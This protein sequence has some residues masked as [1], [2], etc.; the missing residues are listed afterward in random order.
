[1]A[2][3][4]MPPHQGH[5]AGMQSSL[6]AD[7]DLPDA[8]SLVAS[9]TRRA[10][11]GHFDE[12]CAS[13]SGT[14]ASAGHAPAP[15]WRQFFQTLG[16]DGWAD[17]AARAQ[18]VQAQ[19][20]ED[21]ATY[22]V[23]AE[24]V[25]TPRAWPLELL[26][27]IVPAAEWALIEAGVTQRA[28]L[29]AATLT[30]LYGP[31]TLMRDALLPA[32]LVFAH[33]HYL[34]PACGL[35]S[36]DRCGLHIAA[37]DLARTPEGGFQ[38]LAQR[39]QAPSG[40]GYLLESRLIIGAQFQDQFADLRVQR[41]AST[42]R[43]LLDGLVRVSPAGER[44]RVVL[45][46]PGPLNETYFEQ[47]F[48]ARYLGVTLVEGSDLTVR[49]KKLY[50]KTLHGLEQV[51]V[52]LRRVDDEFL[53][54]L[55]LRP[56]SQL[57][58]PGLLQALRAG[59]VVMANSPGAGVLESPGLAAFWPGVAERL[60]G[61]D[62]LLPASTSWWC[63]EPTV[64]QNQRDALANFV[65]APTFPDS[66]FGPRVAALMSEAERLALRDRID[67]DPAA[68]TLQSRV[69]PSETP[70]WAA[71]NSASDDVAGQ[72]HPRA[73]VM[74]VFALADGQGGWQVLPGA[75]TRVANRSSQQPGSAHD[76]WLSMQYGSA[77]VDTWVIASG[78][79][80]KTTL[81]PE[82]LTPEE[83]GGVHRAVSSRA[84][85]NLFWLGR[86][87]ERAENSVRLVRLMLEML[88]D[89]SAPVLRLLDRLARFHGLV[90][91]GVPG[92]LKAPR[93]FER[94]LI[95]GLLPQQAAVPAGSSTGATLGGPTTSVAHNLR[96]LRRCAQNLRERLSPEHWKLIHEVGDHFEQHLRVVLSLGEGH[97]PVPDVLGVLARATT[98]LAAITGAQTDRMTRDDGW[99]LLSVGRQI[100]RLD[101]LSHA[102]SLGFELKVHEADDGFALLLGLFDSVITYRAQFQ[103]RREVLPLLHLLAM[104]TDNPR[105]LAWVART[106]RDRLRKL[107]RHDPIWL[108]Q[109]TRDLLMPE[110]WPLARLARADDKGR[111]AEL[112][113]ALRKCSAGA[114][115][116]SDQISRRLFAH[117]ESRDRTV[118]Q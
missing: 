92:V 73:A 91:A 17:L 96:S 72:L 43:C 9:V 93:V 116:L 7:D 16:A 13:A 4:E 3:G 67:A 107:A 76:P 83:L 58:V 100:E 39:V 66:G 115:G 88:R 30:D 64:W 14:A 23:Y 33:P 28:R 29:M 11:P 15:H 114:R 5:D 18:R 57:G 103:G 87:T 106:M 102:L 22:N 49:G 79:V 110:D 94:A 19:V 48:L 26:P 54:P 99:R 82:P 108:N 80:D 69:R 2:T 41:L 32:S 1:M 60:L 59:E 37:F 12:W 44:S 68:F 55:E 34:R 75:L 89:G 36:E 109:V 31:Q 24:G 112:I 85:E 77:S 6:L 78:V 113:D 47:V 71:G 20:R 42:F 90:G 56:D 97:A 84:A 62:L 65:V 51:H 86:Y 118:W 46:T 111:H 38:V 74:R 95:H 98:H 27:F 8:V 101:M 70:V 25:D 45:L 10:T 63:G 21:G 40:L 105:S 53:D 104:D 35:W 61:E 81:L 52:L 117:V 50:L